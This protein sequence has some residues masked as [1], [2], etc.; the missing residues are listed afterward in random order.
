MIDPLHAL[1][2]S[3]YENPGV[4]CVLLGSGGSRAAEIPTGWEVTLDLVRRVAAL[5]GV[6][7]QTD[8]AAWYKR[9]HGNEPGY[10]ELL[11]QLA[12]T[13]DERRSILHSYIE[14]TP[15]EQEDGKKVP[16]KAHRAIASLVQLGYIKVI[17][18][19]N[20]DRL[21]ENALREVG[22]EPTIIGSE[23]ALKGAVPLIHSR[24]YVVKLHGDYLDTRILNTEAELSAYSS[25][26]NTLLDRIIDEHGLIVSGWS[27]DWDPALRAAITRAPNR[28]YPTFWAARG[29]PSSVAND[30]ITH[31]AGRIIAIDSAETFFETLAR[32]VSS[33]ADAHKQNPQSIELMVSSTK[34]Y[35]AK[36]EFRIQL[37][38]LVGEEA[39]KLDRLLQT[40]DFALT[41]SYSR[42][43][44]VR[45]IARLESVSEPLARIAGVLGRWGT[46]KEFQIITDLLKQFGVRDSAGGLN[47]L[48]NLRTY[49]AVLILYGY[50]LGLL[51]ARRYEELY[52]LFSFTLVA[53]RDTTTPVVGHLLLG[54]WAGGEKEIWRLL[55]GLEKQLTAL[56]DHLHGVFQPWSEDFLFSP[57]GYTQLFE[58]FELLGS[59]AFISLGHDKESLESAVKGQ[60]GN[61]FVWAPI[62]RVS[63]DGQTQ[64]R[65]LDRWR[66]QDTTEQLMRAGFAPPDGDCFDLV[67]KSLGNLAGRLRWS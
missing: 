33:Q 4:Y 58:E 25:A 59:F 7:D 6:A 46:G 49:P 3:V 24:C 60:A 53:E 63:W 64:R 16:T 38:E 23:D 50:G 15:E 66:L 34:R 67:L 51:A 61:N 29:K 31:R 65:I 2:F 35:L 43:L 40:P 52:N 37:D 54:A 48:I 42:E 18:T 19:T 13:P 10:S 1:A 41:G 9:T 44:V 57:G 56:S 62:G 22:I 28:R 39:R 36:P 14:P 27:G 12:A 17:I 21:I 20:F 26:I 11:D 32:L 5:E 30:V 47:V 45:R 55:P 8:W